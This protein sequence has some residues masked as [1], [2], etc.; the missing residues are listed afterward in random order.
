MSFILP[1]NLHWPAIKLAMNGDGSSSYFG[2]HPSVTAD[3]TWPSYDGRPL[4]FLLKLDLAACS[5]LESGLSL[6]KS[7]FLLLFYDTETQ[8][9]GFRPED[10]GCSAVIY[11]DAT[12]TTFSMVPPT[13]SRTFR[14]RGITFEQISTVPDAWSTWLDPLSPTAD[15]RFELDECQRD[16]FNVDGQIGGHPCVIQNSMEAECELAASGFNVGRPEAYQTPEGLRA[17]A[18]A[19][20]QWRLLVQIPSIDELDLMWGDFGMIYF[21]ITEDALRRRDF[22]RCWLVLQCY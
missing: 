5:K 9:W 13:G 1:D 14:R 15:D 2:G 16:L 21:W 11:V 8:P 10:R 20:R 4:D 17:S 7:G 6:P 18:E 12:E 19:H 3:F 22:S